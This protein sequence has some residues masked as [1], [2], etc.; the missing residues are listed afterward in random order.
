MAL[1]LD[2]VTSDEMFP[3][4]YVLKNGKVIGFIE[5]PRDWDLWYAESYL[6]AL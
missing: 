1:P 4:T 2:P 3:E 5:G 6:R